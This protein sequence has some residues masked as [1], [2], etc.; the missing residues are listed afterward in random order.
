LSVRLVGLDLERYGAFTDRSI[1]FREDARLH[2]LYGR[3]EA[4]KSTALAAI[5]DLLFGFEHRTG[6]D[7]LHAASDLRIGA[8]ILGRDGEA[9]AFRRRKGRRDTLIDA[10]D[11]ALRDD[12]LAPFLQGLTRDVFTRA[13]GLSTRT[14][15][16]GAQE[17]LRVDGEVGA[18]LF[19]AASGLR[20]P[21]ELR[22]ALNAE[23]DAIFAPRASKDRRFYQA[24]ESYEAARRLMRESELRVGDWKEL[25]ERIEALREKLE[26]IDRQRAENASEHARLQRLKRL[27]P[28]ALLL[29]RAAAALTR[30]EPVPELPSGFAERL[31]VA[32][33]A[34]AGAAQ[35]HRECLR[36]VEELAQERDGLS[37]DE[38][39]V[40][41]ADEIAALFAETGR[42]AKAKEDLPG[43]DREAEG[44][45]ATLEALAKRL[46]LAQSA[47][48][49]SRQPSDAELA[50][51]RALSREGRAI[52]GELTSLRA[53]LARER[54]SHGLLR[55]DDAARWSPID[56]EPLRERLAALAPVLRR[57][58]QR[59]EIEPAIEAET[60]AIAEAALRL[61]PP[62]A[63]LD[64]LA[65]ASLPAPETIARFHKEHEALVRSSERAREDLRAAER[66]CREIEAALEKLTAA[67]A[68]PSLE[69]IAAA[70]G[71]R[72]TAWVRLRAALFGA[73]LSAPARASSVAT[74]ELQVAHADRLA[75]EALGDAKRVAQHALH[76]R[77]LLVARERQAKAEKTLAEAELAMR[78]HEEKWQAA[79]AASCI[80]PLSPGEMASWSGNVAT[81]LARRARLLEHRQ[82]LCALAA[83]DRSASPV[84]RTAAQAAGLGEL[85]DASSLQLAALLEARLRRLADAWEAARGQQAKLEAS[86]ARIEELDALVQEAAS[87]SAQWSQRWRAL[88]PRLRLSLDATLDEAEA[89][90]DT[91]GEVPEALRLLARE[92]RR[93][94]GM[95]RDNAEF[96][97][98][99]SDLL[100]TSAPDLLEYPCQIATKMLHERAAAAAKAAARRDDCVNRL[101]IAANKEKAAKATREEAQNALASLAGE[102]GLARDENLGALAARLNERSALEKTIREKRDEL[103]RAADGFEEVA[104]RAELSSFDAEAAEQRLADLDRERTRLD[105]ES[106]ESFAALDREERRRAEL[107]T[108]TG[109]ELAAQMRRNAEGELVA[110]AH[111]WAVLKLGVLLL[112]T[113]IER[114]REAA[115]NPLLAR[116]GTLFSALTGGAFVGL[117]S[118]YDEEDRPVLVGRRS[119]DRNVGIEGLSEG[120][121]DQL[122]FAL[123]L[124]YVESYAARLEPPPFI[125]DDIFVTFD[126]ERTG[127]GVEALAEIGASVQCILFTHH[128]RTVE[129]AAERLG[130]EVDV[131]ELSA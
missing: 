12:A 112:G 28:L 66:S 14:L 42:Y 1:R 7:F 93:I 89:A 84:L 26:E 6:F 22:S 79:W 130:K 98:R 80:S 59:A 57:L 8:R 5:T 34:E 3:N 119:Q 13:F 106:N 72:E 104:I 21:G 107:E 47:D 23:A 38:A 46:G 105:R 123:R 92:D 121:R 118:Q 62:V 129:I 122:Y 116:A 94:A 99:V 52:E 49:Q 36:A 24:L 68:V 74:F 111:D 2:V 71:E 95:R 32:L 54:Q 75:D 9:L 86:R 83:E 43:V 55:Q 60:R 27:A 67:R 103:L 128:R 100:S 19:A 125:A 51:L 58:E 44:M 87:R 15:R 45:R 131:V 90:I 81:L 40:A 109:A 101:G 70:R 63:S 18:T 30:A 16:E 108:G 11:K 82:K 124:A 117:G 78:E 76:A 4:G 50:L 113:A 126:D 85:A 115:Q 91:W 77:D 114:H 73:A 35:R 69:A 41:R 31:R 65:G 61:S 37:I 17:M 20:E 29:E 56:P 120:T 48:I 96:E 97:T 25:N 64:E 10:N 102:A 53:N 110:A 33:E 88:L 39:L 127:H